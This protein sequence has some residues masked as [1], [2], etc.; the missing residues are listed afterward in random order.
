M[1]DVRPGPTG[2]CPCEDN[3]SRDAGRCISLFAVS[4]QISTTTSP[5]SK[6]DGTGNW[7]V[8]FDTSLSYPKN[9]PNANLQVKELYHRTPSLD[10]LS[11]IKR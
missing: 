4:A 11:D 6:H 9:V 1:R 2:Y 8:S 3:I 10:R 7:Q 5:G